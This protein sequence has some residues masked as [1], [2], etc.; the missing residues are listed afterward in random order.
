[1]FVTMSQHVLK[2]CYQ[3][4]FIK[5]LEKWLLI[6]KNH[7]QRER[8]RETE[9][10]RGRERKKE[11][12]RERHRER[13]R[14]RKKER[15]TKRERHTERE[16]EREREKDRQTKIRKYLRFYS[17]NQILM[18]ICFRFKKH[19]LE[20]QMFFFNL[21]IFFNFLLHFAISFTYMPS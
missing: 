7:G 2:L 12:K 20:L 6:N 17:F 5:R 3:L 11:R 19:R 4:L 16:R 9:R 15:E 14:K 18:H 1:M 21:L 8:E 10:E 13:E